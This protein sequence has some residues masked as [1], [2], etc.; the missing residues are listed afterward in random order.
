MRKTERPLLPSSFGERLVKTFATSGQLCVGM[1]PSGEQLKQWGLAETAAGAEQFCMQIMDIC[2]G[3][4]GVLK[5]QVSFFEQF[6]SVGFAALERV[7]VRASEAGYMVIAD[8]KRGDIGSTMD[9][10]ARAWLSTEGPFVADAVTVSPYLGSESLGETI[11]FASSNSKGVFLLAATS[12]PE[13]KVL[14]SSVSENQRSVASNVASYA[15]G[16]NKESMGSVGLVIGAQANLIDMAIDPKKLIHTPILAPGFGA[17][18]AKLS[19][20]RSIFGELAEVT[21]FSVSR[22]VAGES[23]VGL[24][25][26]VQN[27]KAE[28]EI[29]L[30]R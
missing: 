26:R 18:G 2:L 11:A 23:P 8:A 25:E 7:L 22:S 21:I 10:Y 20:A 12:N 6:G 28:L 9:G 24:R 19:Q 16:F 5:P 27:A 14:Q 30:S 29:G 17:Q 13:G 3:E 4:I 15:A 1:D